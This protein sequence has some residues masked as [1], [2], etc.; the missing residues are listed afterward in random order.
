MKIMEQSHPHSPYAAGGN[1]WVPVADGF[2]IPDDAVLYTITED[3]GKPLGQI[4]VDPTCNNIWEC[5]LTILDMSC[6]DRSKLTANKVLEAFEAHVRE[7]FEAAIV[8]LSALHEKAVAF[9]Q[10]HDYAQI[11]DLD[12]E[13]SDVM[14]TLIKSL[15]ES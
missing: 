5:S 15:V 2:S 4:L 8:E 12:F 11:A 1:T 3:D 9:W 14:I 7:H 13:D 10:S 6:V